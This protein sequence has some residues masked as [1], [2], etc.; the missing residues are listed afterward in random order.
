MSSFALSVVI[1]AYNAEDWIEPTVG[2]IGVAMDR[3]GID[4]Y[5]VIIVDDGSSDGTRSASQRL[6]DIPGSH[7]KVLHHTNSGRYLTR[8]RG[9][10]AARFERILFVDTRVW[11][12]EDALNFLREQ[13][14]SHADRVIWNG[15]IN[16]AKKGNVI[17]RFGDAL[18]ILGWRR[19]FKSPRLTSYGVKDFDHY[20]KGTGLF[21]VP[22]A[23]IIEAFEWFERNTTD[24]K[25]SSDDTLLIRHLAESNRI[26]LS[27]EFSATYFARTTLKAFIKHT[28]YR[29]QFFVDG[30]LRPGTRFFFPL[31][32]FL[33]LSFVL[34]MLVLIFPG[35]ITPIFMI[36]GTVWLFG[37]VI[38]LIFGLKF[39][40]AVALLVLSP[41][42]AFFY[43]VGIWVA[44][45]KRGKRR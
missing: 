31:L 23:L 40:D 28:Y 20:P 11:M 16:V 39:K 35:A 44:V 36:L 3:A 15:H 29:G 42:F 24:I 27:P 2:K 45:I 1:P 6:A 10:E 17:A 5:E 30:F 43:S 37:F 4:T 7:V 14:D 18:T 22:K 33:A 8:K 19:Y 9:V 13:T 25:N 26:W 21:M 12:D 34:A 41:I 38:A 32:S